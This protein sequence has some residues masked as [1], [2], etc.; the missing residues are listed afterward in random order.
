[1]EIFVGTYMRHWF[2]PCQ[3]RV[4]NAETPFSGLFAAL[5][6]ILGAFIFDEV[7]KTWGLFVVSNVRKRTVQLRY[8]FHKIT[9]SQPY[10]NVLSLIEKRNQRVYFTG[11]F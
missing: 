11:L 3:L 5:R 1:M 8:N 2:F 4:A 10:F 6:L 7:L 9:H